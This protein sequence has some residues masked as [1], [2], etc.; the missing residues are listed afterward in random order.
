MFASDIVRALLAV[1]RQIAVGEVVAGLNC[2]AGNPSALENR[3]RGAWE[4][5]LTDLVGSQTLGGPYRIVVRK[6]DVK[7]LFIPVVLELVDDHR[8]HLSH[9][10]IHTFHPTVA[11]CM[12]E[13]VAIFITPRS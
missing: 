1:R 12:E 9:R 2:L 7:E 3:E 11:V 8:K 10:V 6:F 5:T 13:L 4:R